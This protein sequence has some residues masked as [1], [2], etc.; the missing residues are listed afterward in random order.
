[1]RNTWHCKCNA[2]QSA[3]KNLR[4]QTQQSEI[5]AEPK[6]VKLQQGLNNEE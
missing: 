2:N 4:D 3:M 5:R 6:M 1:M